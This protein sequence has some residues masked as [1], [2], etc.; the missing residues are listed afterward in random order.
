RLVA[1][2]HSRMGSGRSGPSL[3]ALGFEGGHLLEALERFRGAIVIQEDLALHEPWFRVIPSKGD[4]AVV[5]LD[6]RTPTAFPL[7]E[8]AFSEKDW[9]VLRVLLDCA[10]ELRLR[11]VLLRYD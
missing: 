11:D 3:D 1:L 8:L 6:R 5:V 7:E 2:P 10:C 9:R 4:R